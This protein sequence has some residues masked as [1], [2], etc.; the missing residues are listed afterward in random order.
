MSEL[1]FLR[2]ADPYIEAP[3]TELEQ[4]IMENLPVRSFLQR[5]AQI[6]TMPQT[7]F[8]LF[9]V[10]RTQ[11]NPSIHSWLDLMR[12]MLYMYHNRHKHLTITR[13][14]DHPELIGQSSIPI[15]QGV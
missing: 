5:L 4:K 8:A 9:I 1:R 7:S 2:K 15:G 6:R 14:T 3:T 10:S 13:T 11:V 12:V